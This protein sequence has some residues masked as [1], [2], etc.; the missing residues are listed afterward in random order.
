MSLKTMTQ[1]R[2]FYHDTVN[3]FTKIYGDKTTVA[4]MCGSMYNFFD[5]QARMSNEVA[6]L[7]YTSQ[8][9]TGFPPQSLSHWVKKFTDQGFVVVIMDQFTRKKKNGCEEIYRKPV[10]IYGPGTP[11][12][13][14]YDCDSAV[15]AVVYVDDTPGKIG[16]ATFES[17]T[18][19]TQACEFVE[20]TF[21]SAFGGLL[22]A[23]LADSPSHTLVV[24]TDSPDGDKSIELF[25]KRAGNMQV[26]GKRVDYK[27][28]DCTTLRD[29]HIKE[30]IREQF[31]GCGMMSGSS[32]TYIGLGGRRYAT[33]AFA[34]LVH[35][36]FRRDETKL[37][38]MD[39]PC[40][41][42]HRANLDVAIEG[43][44]QLDITGKEGLLY[45]LP[46]PC[47]S[48]G[49][50]AFR[51][52]VCRPS[53]DPVEIDRR[54]DTVARAIPNVK[55]ARRMLAGISDVETLHRKMSRPV[56]FRPA[57]FSKLSESLTAVHI[58]SRMIYGDRPGQHPAVAATDRLESVIDIDSC[59]YSEE[60]VFSKGLD[61]EYDI[62]VRLRDE[63]NA[64]LE[65]L[66][67]YMNHCSGALTD[68]YFKT[69]ETRDDGIEICITQK[70]FDVA[71]RNMFRNKRIFTL[72][73]RQVHT[74]NFGL[75]QHPTKKNERIISDDGLQ[76]GLVEVFERRRLVRIKTQEM[77]EKWCPDLK[78]DIAENVFLCAR[79]L[80]DMDVACACAIMAAEK[81]FV[82][83]EIV[84][85]Q[86]SF[87]ESENL[88]HP[89][90]EDLDGPHEYVGNDVS[91]DDNHPGMILYGIN[92]SGKSCLMKSIGIAVCMAQAGMYVSASR[93][94]I[95]PFARLF[96]R[97]WN[98][99]DI[100]RGMSTF[101]KEMIEMKEIL[102]RGDSA[103]LVLGDELCSGTERYSATA[104]I[105]SGI[106]I[107]SKQ[108]CRFLLATHQHDVVDKIDGIGSVRVKHL[109]VNL[110]DRGELVYE[111][112]LRDGHGE[113]TYGVIVCRALGMPL[114][115]LESA[116]A[117]VRSMQGNDPDYAVSIKKSNYNPDVYLGMCKRCG[118]RVAV[119]THHRDP[120]CSA[121]KRI[122]NAAHNLEALCAECHE[123]HHRRERSG[124]VIPTKVVQTTSGLTEIPIDIS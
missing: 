10:E 118:K 12:E 71:R 124:L 79:E 26:F 97:I 45:H 107:L 105:T 81:N 11:I 110:D 94:R 75:R 51:Q 9:M 24:H 62:A 89:I 69:S 47:T 64:E 7:R 21:E 77:H 50:R 18:G 112:K 119:H 80:E 108:G 76:E 120:Q 2:K 44:R 111:R 95:G 33:R 32:D 8:D 6:G 60:T 100:N 35:F 123:E 22:G 1:H 121:Q 68:Q 104:I 38:I 117:H 3:E 106:E 86:G 83:P 42:S 34:H 88:R 41:I 84:S 102:T 56:S 13:L 59:K 99:D 17:N 54:L 82:R 14:P 20:G 70:R 46:K 5:D 55:E 85:G 31:D 101:M 43:L 30:T 98:N 28:V 78:D 29:S 61:D 36:I 92:G 65:A 91:L 96:T 57:D 37:R 49:R 4:M 53:R 48:S 15:C 39:Q 52:R 16:Y 19:K 116:M 93:V 87:F 113:T 66:M 73:G 114:D 72:A 25:K 90:V 103:S 40:L 122:K 23:V 58:V 109:S 27:A 67:D 63:A 74:A 115:F